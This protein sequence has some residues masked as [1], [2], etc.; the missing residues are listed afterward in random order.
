[1]NSYQ[2]AVAAVKS[3][4]HQPSRNCCHARQVVNILHSTLTANL[5]IRQWLTENL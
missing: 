4:Q 2:T 3:L 5:D 1:M